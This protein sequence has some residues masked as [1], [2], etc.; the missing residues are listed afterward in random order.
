MSTRLINLS[1]LVIVFLLILASIYLQV[2][3]GMAPCPLCT[4][5]R[6]TFVIIG[7]ICL[8]GIFIYKRTWQRLIINAL[9]LLFSIVGIGLAGRQI[10]IQ[11]LNP[12]NDQCGVSLQYMM[13]I[14]PLNKVIERALAG[15][16]ECSERGWEF[17]HLNIAEWSLISFVLFLLISL[18]LFL[19]EI[20]E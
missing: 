8:I 20:K 13:K 16:A 3:D 17:L 2:Y 14:L 1:G 10:W 5:Q 7:F 12:N 11:Q 6:L 15:S 9:L 18:Y 4:L 19:R